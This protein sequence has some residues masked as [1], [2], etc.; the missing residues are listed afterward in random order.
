MLT[1]IWRQSEQ[2][3]VMFCAMLTYYEVTLLDMFHVFVE[4]P[5]VLDP[6]GRPHNGSIVGSWKLVS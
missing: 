3:F 1:K 6:K 4:F 2:Y 5:E